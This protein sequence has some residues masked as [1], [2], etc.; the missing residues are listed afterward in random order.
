MIHI[1]K[2]SNLEKVYI[3]LC[4]LLFVMIFYHNCSNVHAID[5]FTKE[6]DKESMS[7]PTNIGMLYEK[8]VAQLIKNQKMDVV[9]NQGMYTNACV[10]VRKYPNT[11]SE[12]LLIL[13]PNAKVSAMGHNNNG[14]YQIHIE[15][16]NGENLFGYINEDFLS[17]EE[18]PTSKLNRWGIELDEDEINL[19]AQIL[20]VEARAEPYD[21][22]VAVVEVIFNRIISDDG[23][24]QEDNLTG[25]VS[26][27]KDGTQFDSWRLRHTAS[28]D[29]DIYKVIDN[30][31]DG[32]SET[33]PSTDYIYFS[34]HQLGMN[35]I[36][37]G[38]HYFGT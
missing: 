38:S 5:N 23:N 16:E 27:R 1:N 2:Y 32:I 14:W 25:I 18:T 20:W 11:K 35:I 37:V 13:R 24:F 6:T 15:R 33:L 36:K 7:Y 26:S 3:I 22:Q 29:E 31:L 30:V 17:E 8:Y 10:N 28:P 34:R 19:L 4:L 12:I 9:S 21:G